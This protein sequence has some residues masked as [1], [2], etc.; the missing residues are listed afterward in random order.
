MNMDND[1][2]ANL[3]LP[4]FDAPCLAQRPAS[5]RRLLQTGHY[6]GTEYLHGQFAR[7]SQPNGD[8]IRQDG[9]AS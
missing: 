2:G 9:R 1:S 6:R 4:M 5:G 7:A 3:P 8:L